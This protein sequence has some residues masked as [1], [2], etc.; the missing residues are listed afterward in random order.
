VTV[1]GSPSRDGRN[2]YHACGD[3]ENHPRSTAAM[4]GSKLEKITIAGAA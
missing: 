1:N 4:G 2:N 3:R